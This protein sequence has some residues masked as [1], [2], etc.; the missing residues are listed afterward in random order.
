MSIIYK[1]TSKG[2]ERVKSFYLVLDGRQTLEFFTQ[3]YG[4]LI[5]ISSEA[6]DKGIRVKRNGVYTVSCEKLNRENRRNA[7]KD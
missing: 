3:G 2:D 5:R 1:L 4:G 7:P 6:L